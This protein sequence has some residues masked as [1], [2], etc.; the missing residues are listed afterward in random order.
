MTPSII[1]AMLMAKTGTV[2]W[3]DPLEIS[4]ILKKRK[5]RLPNTRRSN[6]KAQQNHCDVTPIVDPALVL[7]NG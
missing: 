2:A 4:K 1:I 7:V 6:P 5:I 3:M